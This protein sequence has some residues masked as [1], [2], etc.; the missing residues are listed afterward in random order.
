M[1]H[2]QKLPPPISILNYTFLLVLADKL[3]HSEWQVQ[4]EDETSSI[5]TYLIFPWTDDKLLC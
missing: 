2:F 1:K 3:P 4:Q 5:D